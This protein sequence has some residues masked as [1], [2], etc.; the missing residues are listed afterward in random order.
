MPGV[1]VK[2]LPATA[3][4]YDCAHEIHVDSCEHTLGEREISPKLPAAVMMGKGLKVGKGMGLKV[5]KGTGLKVGKGTGAG[6]HSHPWNPAEQLVQ[7]LSSLS[8][9]RHRDMHCECAP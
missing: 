8:H 6:V 5:G 1:R 9:T 2:T 7:Q 3:N 4:V